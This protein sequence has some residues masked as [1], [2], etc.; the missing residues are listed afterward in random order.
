LRVLEG[1]AVVAKAATDR[2][3]PDEE[4]AEIRDRLQDGA[5]V[6]LSLRKRVGVR[7]YRL[8]WRGR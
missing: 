8:I 2:R 1:V 5:L 6:S 7:G 4:S 3:Q